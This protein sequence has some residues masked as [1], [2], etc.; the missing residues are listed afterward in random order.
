MGLE[1]LRPTLLSSNRATGA[2]VSDTVGFAGE[3]KERYINRDAFA[4]TN[5]YG[6]G[7]QPNV[8]RKLRQPD[9]NVTDLALM[10]NFRFT[11]ACF[12]QVRFEA[13]NAF[14]HPVFNLG[15]NDLNIQSATF[16]YMN[17][18]I[19]QPRNIQFGARFVF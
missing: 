15:G 19:S 6:I 8:L 16:G 13:Q 3:A 4:V 9:F 7:N 14:N 5:R 17:S 11:E 18:V 10:K 2:K 12:L 1:G